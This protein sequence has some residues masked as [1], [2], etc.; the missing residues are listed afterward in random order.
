MFW[1]LTGTRDTDTQFGRDR[2]MGRDE[3]ERHGPALL[4]GERTPRMTDTKI[5]VTETQ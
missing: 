4:N 1:D 3:S 5:L 2:E